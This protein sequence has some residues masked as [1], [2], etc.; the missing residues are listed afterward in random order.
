[1]ISYKFVSTAGAVLFGGLFLAILFNAGG[2]IGSWG[3]ATT[4]EAEFV[5]RRLAA[6]FLGLAVMCILSRNL[7]ASEA[8]R[9]LALGISAALLMVAT[10]G[11]YEYLRGFAGS[12]ILTAIGFELVFA[13]GFIATG[14]QSA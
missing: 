13:A 7:A 3:V 14:R 4:P 1:M 11:I 2:V 8:R 12:G 5:G 6:S 10:F 9:T